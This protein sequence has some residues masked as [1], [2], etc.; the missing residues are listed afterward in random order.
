MPAM[1]VHR[2][3][4]ASLG[5]DYLRA[6]LG[7]ALTAGPLAL[8]GPGAAAA[9]VLGPVGLLFAVH[10][11]WTLRRHL[12]VVTCGDGGLSL[13]GPAARRLAW[14]ELTEMRLRYFST[15]RDRERGW[16]QLSLAGGGVTVRLDSTIDGFE[17]I[18]R[19]AARA[20]AAADVALGD[21]T[22]R[23]LESLGI[24]APARR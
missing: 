6:G 17:D 9:W 2:H 8:A 1:T 12:T 3:G 5:G 10:G 4:L 22:V 23:N 18:V 21:A 14:P 16:M 19:R 20:A 24:T 11:L 15:R 13:A 7:L